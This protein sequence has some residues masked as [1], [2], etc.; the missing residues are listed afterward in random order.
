MRS[1]ATRGGAPVEAP[2]ATTTPQRSGTSGTKGFSGGSHRGSIYQHT[3]RPHISG[4]RPGAP[5]P[6]RP[7]PNPQASNHHDEHAIHPDDLRAAVEEAARQ[8]GGDGQRR[9]RSGTSARQMFTPPV[10]APGQPR[11]QALPA[12][13][14]SAG[15]ALRRSTGPDV[16]RL[17]APPSPGGMPWATLFATLAA[18]YFGT[19]GNTTARRVCASQGARR[20]LPPDAPPVTMSVVK[21]C[22]IG[23]MQAHHGGRMVAPTPA[24]QHSNVLFPLYVHT[25]ARQQVG[26]AKAPGDACAEI[27]LCGLA[28]MLKEK[29]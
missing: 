14:V 16:A 4:P 7:P 3:S 21:A 6:R 18:A 28:L 13:P 27:L 19:Q 20:Q 10:Q 12:K 5:R 26:E 25:S 15:A 29:P 22:S 17:L 9:Q 24:Q 23:Y 1:E 8:I 11:P 2:V